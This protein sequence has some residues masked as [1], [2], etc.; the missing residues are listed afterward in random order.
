MYRFDHVV[1]EV[2]AI[3]A[4]DCRVVRQDAAANVD[5]YMR[6]DDC[7]DAAASKAPLEVDPRPGSGTVIVIDTSR[8]AGS[9]QPVPYLQI[10]KSNRLEKDVPVHQIP[11]SL[12]F[13]SSLPSTRVSNP[14]PLSS[15]QHQEMRVGR[16]DPFRLGRFR[17][18]HVFEIIPHSSKKAVSG[19]K[20]YVVS[21]SRWIFVA[22]HLTLFLTN[23]SHWRRV[24]V[25]RAS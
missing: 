12:T 11:L 23:S 21:T 7:S 6:G 2:D 3:V 20:G 17:I 9:K 1:P 14:P 22:R 18:M 15:H 19:H 4:V 13:W 16:T 8:N 5:R 25:V 10:A 24:Q